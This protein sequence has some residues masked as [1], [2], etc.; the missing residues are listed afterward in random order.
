M[1]T[2]AQSS[3]TPEFA[4]GLRDV[5]L[6]TIASE[7]DITQR[8]LAAI[9]DTKTD[10]KHD[11]K[12]RTALELATHVVESD[13]WFMNSIADGAFNFDPEKSLKPFQSSAEAVA[14]Y[15][16]NFQ[17]A[18]DRVAKLPGEKLIQVVDFFGMKMPNYQYLLFQIVHAVHHRG[19]LSTYLRPM[20]GKV[21][22]IYGGS[23]DEPWQQ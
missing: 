15:D 17:A 6:Q 10:Y 19:Q 8:V 22:D 13:V 14:W 1:S 16:Q 12:G 18:F 11:P 2:A 20:G 4:A 3:V 21:P 9:P 7:R 23:A 5:L